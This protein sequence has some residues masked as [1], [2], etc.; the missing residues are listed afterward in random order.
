MYC[1][2]SR[3]RRVH[4]ARWGRLHSRAGAI[5]LRAPRP[6]Q[7]EPRSSRS[8]RRLWLRAVFWGFLAGAADGAG[9]SAGAAASAGVAC[10]APDGGAEPCGSS[11]PLAA[12]A[13][14]AVLRP[15]GARPIAG[16]RWPH[17]GA[18]CA[19]CPAEHI[20]VEIGPR[21]VVARRLAA[22][23]PPA[24]ACP[25]WTCRRSRAAPCWRPRSGWAL[26]QALGSE[27]RLACGVGCA[28]GAGSEAGCAADASTRA[29]VVGPSVLVS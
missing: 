22:A 9:G 7:K 25:R 21:A 10:A 19:V 13:A 28:V 23:A 14:G 8:R 3:I 4:S 20:P 26:F 6:R 12:G 29:V 18:A 16:H 24:S 17:A 27:A 1:L 15:T 5:H 2:R 11:E